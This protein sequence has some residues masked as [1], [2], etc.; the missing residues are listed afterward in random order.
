MP[1]AGRYGYCLELDGDIQGFVGSC[2][3]PTA[4]SM[5]LGCGTLRSPSFYRWIQQ[6]QSGRGGAKSGKLYNCRPNGDVETIIK[7]DSATISSVW[8]PAGD[9]ADNRSTSLHVVLQTPFLSQSQPSFS[10]RMTDTS[11]RIEWRSSNFR[12]DID[13]VNCCKVM[14]VDPVVL[15]IAPGAPLTNVIHSFNNPSLTGWT[16][17]SSFSLSMNAVTFTFRQGISDFLAWRQAGNLGR[18]GSVSMLAPDFATVLG[19]LAFSNLQIH[20]MTSSLTGPIQ[21]NGAPPAGASYSPFL[22]SFQSY[23]YSSQTQNGGASKSDLNPGEKISIC[24]TYAGVTFA[25]PLAS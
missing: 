20:S 4:A 15:S 19:Q 22:K 3:A 18:S 17:R 24:L 8:F 12:V 11:A 6:S 23:T 1:M 25:T 21:L 13:G 2:F 9:A 7:F 16:T 10:I 14:D 5:V